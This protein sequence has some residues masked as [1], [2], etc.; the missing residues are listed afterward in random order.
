MITLTLEELKTYLN[1]EIA[2]SDWIEITQTQIN[3]FAK[4]TGDFQWIH[5]DE[6]KAKT[7]SPFQK[8]IAHGFFLLSL[9]PKLIYEMMQVVGV[10]MALNYGTD[11]VRFIVPVV[12]GSKVRMKVELLEWEQKEDNSVQTKMLLTFELQNSEKPACVAEVLIRYF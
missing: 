7:H 10:K 5:V 4:A 2:L 11:K 6:E 1:Q 8:T 3:L 12:V 9:Y